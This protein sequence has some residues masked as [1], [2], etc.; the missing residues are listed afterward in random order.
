MNIGSI[1]IGVLL[2][3]GL[4]VAIG[5]MNRGNGPCGGDCSTCVMS[6]HCEKLEEAKKKKK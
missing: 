6:E 2:I 4:V 5:K 3:I 1:V